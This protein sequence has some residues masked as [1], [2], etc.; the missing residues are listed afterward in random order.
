MCVKSKHHMIYQPL[1]SW[2]LPSGQ[3][4]RDTGGT[5]GLMDPLEK[6]SFP[7]PLTG[8]NQGPRSCPRMPSGILHMLSSGLGLGLAPSLILP[9][10]H[11][12][13]QPSPMC[14]WA[15]LRVSHS[16]ASNSLI[17]SPS[18]AFSGSPLPPNKA[19]VPTQSRPLFRQSP[20]GPQWCPMP[21]RFPTDLPT[22]VKGVNKTPITKA[23]YYHR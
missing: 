15:D 13:T 16:E 18:A 20:W 8:E 4:Q 21:H 10:S 12:N 22:Q 17:L 19:H 9:S 3:P 2:P 1:F 23:H 14:V 7:P 5:S 11:P 6:V